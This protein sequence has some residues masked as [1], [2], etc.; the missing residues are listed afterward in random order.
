VQGQHEV[1]ARA[2][3]AAPAAAGPADRR[4]TLGAPAEAR[5]SASQA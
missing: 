5:G 1:A 2:S 4:G 3:P